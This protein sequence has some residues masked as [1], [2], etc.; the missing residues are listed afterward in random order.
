MSVYIYKFCD[1]IDSINNCSLE[2]SYDNVCI[3]KLKFV[4]KNR[5]LNYELNALQSKSKYV[6]NSLH[7][8][9][10]VFTVKSN[11]ISDIMIF[12]IN[13]QDYAVNVLI[14]KTNF[15]VKSENLEYIYNIDNNDN[16]IHTND[17]DIKL[18]LINFIEI[19]KILT[20]S[21]FITIK[22][23]NNL[24]CVNSQI[25]NVQISYYLSRL[26]S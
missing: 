18:S 16:N 20:V 10:S 19:F 13:K 25:G 12:D 26:I 1:I 2:L 8:Y 4:N 22:S 11:L 5:I 23:V 9:D 15:I 17:I 3:L 14:N 6:D 21:D 7:I 24:F